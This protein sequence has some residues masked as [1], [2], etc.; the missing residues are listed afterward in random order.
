MPDSEKF[1]EGVAKEKVQSRIDHY[2][3]IL[4]AEDVD[5]ESAE[6]VYAQDVIEEITSLLKKADER[7]SFVNNIDIQNRIE[8]YFKRLEY[9]DQD[10]LTSKK[11][12]LEGKVEELDESSSLD[13][14]EEKE[15]TLDELLAEIDRVSKME[16]VPPALD[17]IQAWRSSRS[18]SNS[19]VKE[20]LE[21]IKKAIEDLS[22]RDENDIEV[23]KRVT[24]NRINELQELSKEKE[25]FKIT[26][27]GEVVID[28]PEVKP[29]PDIEAA[30]EEYQKRK[31]DML[32]K[33][34]G[35]KEKAKMYSAAMATLKS[36]VVE[37]EFEFKDKN[38]NTKKA[39]YQTVE[40]YEGMQ[41]D[42]EL[43]QLEEYAERLERLTKAQAGDLS[44]YQ[45]VKTRDEKGN[46]V[47][48]S[49]E[50][51]RKA[52]ERYIETNN[53]AYNKLVATRENLKTLGKYGEKVPYSQFQKHQVVRNIFRAIGN[54]GKFVR[55]HVTAPINKFVGSKIVAPIYG[56]VTGAD[57][58]VKGLYSNKATHRYVARREYYQS[59]GKGFFSSRFN[60]IFR[61]KEGNKAILSAGAYEI[62]ESVRQKYIQL[63]MQEAFDKKT[64]FASKSMDEKIAMLQ[65]EMEKV[66]DEKAKAEF[67]ARLADL[68]KA[69]VQIAADKAAN[70]KVGAVQT[71]QTD[72]ID[73]RQHDK[74]NKE[75][76][77]RT[78]TGVKLATRLGF[79]K[80]IGPKIKDWLLGHTKKTQVT[81]TPPSQEEMESALGLQDKKWVETT[82]KQ[83]PVPVTETRINS[84]VSMSEMM[85]SNAGK[86]IE[87]YYSVYG[88]AKRP[89]MYDLTGN[90]KITAIFESTENGGKG[91]SDLAGLKAPTLTDGTFAKELLDAN[92]V[93][94][95]DITMDEILN[96]IGN[97]S[98]KAE[99]LSNIY[100]GVGDRYWAKLSDLCQDLTQEVTVG[101]KMGTVIDVAG[102][103]E[104]LST[105]ERVQAI[106]YAMQEALRDPLKRAKID[107]LYKTTTEVVP[108][109]RV[110]RVLD[111]LGMGGR[112]AGGMLLA[113][114]VYE[115]L[116][117]TDSKLAASKSEPRPYDTKLKFTGKRKEDLGQKSRRQQK[118][119]DER[120]ER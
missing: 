35:N 114:D 96:A 6:Y 72:A 47:E 119:S 66:T 53:S 11:E 67:E 40:S 99:D 15:Q 89:A 112:V 113:D 10:Y 79:T 86:Q 115:N 22:G 104:P 44:V 34:Y 2:N 38:G 37:K 18:K 98:L 85:S 55:N 70:Q 9:I 69:K 5:K 87:G 68:E 100:V 29:E 117:H 76:V 42:L 111:G 27:K 108:N 46:I 31:Q 97:S 39:M 95:Q 93:L 106:Q 63:G 49:P 21:E 71:V 83:E 23:Q 8:E 81:T 74:A 16:V 64:E 30:K 45:G 118:S 43:L 73:I 58:K 92:G 120:G 84:D 3:S 26:E 28:Y 105:A 77:T 80:L 56:K 103:Y 88:G 107:S 65:T 61:A 90:E 36:H 4:N 60:S 101:S 7:R 82:Y 94:R 24:K 109:E 57:H 62:Y 116:R 75:N 110:V 13:D 48:V 12:E 25:L 51:A 54:A 52:D 32:D 41:A 19:E 1:V 33:F 14:E 102:H 91:L 59:Q 78:I 17:E 50:E 20:E